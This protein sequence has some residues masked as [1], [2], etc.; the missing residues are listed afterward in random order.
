[1]KKFYLLIVS[2]ILYMGSLA[3]AQT[4]ELVTRH[5]DLNNWSV[6]NTIKNYFDQQG[7]Y[8][9]YFHNLKSPRRDELV[10]LNA[11]TNQWEHL[12][13][14]TGPLPSN[15][16]GTTA[17]VPL[18]D[19]SL[20][21]FATTFNKTLYGYHLKT[22]GEIT[23]FSG[24]AAALGSSVDVAAAIDKDNNFYGFYEILGDD[25][26]GD[27]LFGVKWNGSSWSNLP[28]ISGNVNSF[29]DVYIADDNTIYLSHNESVLSG[30]SPSF[31]N[32]KKLAPNATQWE[33]ILREELTSTHFNS[34]LFISPTEMY[35]TRIGG[36]RFYNV[37]KFDGTNLTNL[38]NTM[39]SEQNV[40]EGRLIKLKNNGELYLATDERPNGIYRHDSN[41]NTWIKLP[42]NTIPGNTNDVG[43]ILT[44]APN[45]YVYS[46]FGDYNLELSSSDL[47]T[48]R[49]ISEN[50]GVNEFS[51]LENQLLVYPNPTTGKIYINSN[52]KNLIQNVDV[53]SILGQKVL[54][55][56]LKSKVSN[57]E[58]DLSA[59]PKGTYIIQ[60]QDQSRKSTNHKIIK[61]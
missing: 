60:I 3:Q 29:I 23:I 7:N 32:I 21:A 33:T 25:E 26:S 51:I 41:S 42:N 35:I 59:L 39:P 6:G 17:A 43:S 10:R 38:G 13:S 30:S 55:H 16:R 49:F 20:Y 27:G 44:E 58:I 5:L 12:T 54:N 47:T 40:S 50:L 52:S 24:D 57:T 45:G 34:V 22:N 46:S 36:E 37:R 31:F 19:G 9:V 8:Y 11:Q 28:Q 61:K 1:M 2:S 53:Y 18:P 14:N 56:N 4:Y 15:S 48:V